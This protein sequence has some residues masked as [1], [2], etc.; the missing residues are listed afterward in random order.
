[1][2]RLLRAMIVSSLLGVSLA[3]GPQAASSAQ[4]APCVTIYRIYYNS[5]GS[6]DGSN[7]SLNAEWI[8]LHNSCGTG[9]SLSNW[10][11]KDLAGH[12]YTFGTY[13]LGAGAYVKV[14]TGK[15]SNTSTDRYWA[16]AAYI[17]NNDRD[18]AYLRNGAGTLIDSCS[19]NKPSASSAY[20]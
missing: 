1:M 18:T 4:A 5:P 16:R 10:K 3:A 14:H 9:K 15:G 7:G 11:I 2:R 20:C 8:R 17:W 19:Y 12:T 6:D 13:T